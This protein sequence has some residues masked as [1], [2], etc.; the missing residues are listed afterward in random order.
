MSTSH[1]DAERDERT[2]T[3]VA[4]FPAFHQPSDCIKTVRRIGGMFGRILRPHCDWRA[5]EG[6]IVDPQFRSS[7][8]VYSFR[9]ASEVGAKLR[10]VLG[11]EE[12]QPTLSTL[13][14]V[15]RLAPEIFALHEL[16]LT[17]GMIAEGLARFGVDVTETELASCFPSLSD[18]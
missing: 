2:N 1:E 15:R 6:T 12:A 13:E 5:F 8:K 16:G 9:N 11:I 4:Q 17:L 14:M 10:D 3:L 7:A 18:A